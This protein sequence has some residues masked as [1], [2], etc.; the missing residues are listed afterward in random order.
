MHILSCRGK[1]LSM[2]GPLPHVGV[3]RPAWPTT[4]HR[5]GP[6]LSALETSGFDKDCKI[7][8][9]QCYCS[10]AGTDVRCA[11]VRICLV[12][13]CP[14]TI[15][16]MPWC[17]YALVSICP[18]TGMPCPGIDMPGYRYARVPLCPGTGMPGYQYAL[19]PLCPGTSMPGYHYARVPVCPGTSMPWYRYA[20]VPICTI[21]VSP[22]VLL[23]PV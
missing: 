21:A 17:R 6:C 8:Q 18:S 7:D 14:G 4:T 10:L 5:C 1:K 12:P 11:R 19:V 22:H 15:I 23:N 20:R 3:P 16:Y 13:V 9:I 2:H